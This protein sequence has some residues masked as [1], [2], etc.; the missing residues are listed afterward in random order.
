M[1]D[2][3]KQIKEKI[4]CCSCGGSLADSETINTVC[5]MKEAEWSHPT[6]GSTALSVYGFATAIICD[7]CLKEKKKPKWA[8]EWDQRTLAAKYHPVE[9]LKNV[10]REIFLPLALLDL[11]YEYG[12]HGIA[13]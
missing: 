13:G 3:V 4:K 11:E 10:P 8:V 5:L 6:W 2:L 7:K 1:S 9:K 12:R